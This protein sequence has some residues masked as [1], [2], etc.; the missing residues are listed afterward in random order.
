MTNSKN[1]RKIYYWAPF[2]SNIAT[3]K[4]VMNSAESLIK[5]G[6]QNFKP[7]I[8]NAVGEWDNYLC[9]QYENKVPII[10]L[11]NFKLYNFI[12]NNGYLTSRLIYLITFICCFWK[13]KKFIQR[14]NPDYIILHLITSLPLFLLIFFKFKTKFVLRISGYPK[15]NFFRKF[16]WYLA[17]KKIFLVS[18]PS[19]STFEKIKNTNLFDIKKLTI[20]YD[21]V[22]KIREIAI[23]KKEKINSKFTDSQYLL[24]IGRLTRQKNFEYMLKQFSII[25]KKKKELKLIIIG[26][27]EEQKKL[28]KLAKEKNIY[29]SVLFLGNQNNVFKFLN[30]AKCFLLSSSWEDPGFVLI[31]AAACNTPIISSMCPNGPKDFFANNS[32][33]GYS[34]D[35]NSKNGLSE[36]F[37]KFYSDSEK[38]IF[39]KKLNAKK[40]I[41]KFSFYS[42]YLSISRILI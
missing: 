36:A 7:S 28:I 35:L 39:L 21:P 26:K 25:I 23:L 11:T 42:H 41:N 8:I 29:K 33:N 3:P 5:Y 37:E 30:N 24:A 15:L 38:N 14:D 32:N 17:R 6:Y 1:F 34:F 9:N 4:A 27:G 19:K 12:Q 20:L 10:N 40:Y 31:E 18:S 16:L 2:S 13:L 22:F